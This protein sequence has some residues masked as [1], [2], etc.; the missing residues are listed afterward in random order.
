MPHSAEEFKKL[1]EKKGMI[2]TKNYLIEGNIISEGSVIRLKEDKIG[3]LPTDVWE[4]VKTI[5]DEE[6]QFEFVKTKLGDEFTDDEIKD[7]L[8]QHKNDIN[9]KSLKEDKIGFL[10][11]DI[12]N[13]A[14]EIS[15]EAER[16]EYIKKELGDEFTD[17]EIKDFL[18]K[19]K[20][21][22]N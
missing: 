4:K 17:D 5:D 15:D 21:E 10:P 6:K 1:M 18:N 8:N 12:W 7:F 20:K 16:F 22:L 14:K 9:K 11:T 13:K 3:F 2:L 19:Y